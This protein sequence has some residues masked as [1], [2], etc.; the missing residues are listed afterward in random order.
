[1]VFTVKM[2]QVKLANQRNVIINSDKTV[3]KTGFLRRGLGKIKKIEK[4]I[5]NYLVISL[6]NN[7]VSSNF[8]RTFCRKLNIL[9][10]VF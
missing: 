7:Q 2:Q 9:T 4:Q 3:A 6:L 1:M 10:R 5:L 8:M